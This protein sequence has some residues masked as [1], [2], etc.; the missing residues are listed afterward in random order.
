MHR[1]LNKISEWKLRGKPLWLGEYL[2]LE[3]INYRAARFVIPITVIE[4]KGNVGI[5]TGTVINPNT[6]L[7]CA[8][9]LNDIVVNDYIT[10]N[11]K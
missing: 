3:Y 1:K 4:S 6:I 11:G 2:E 7:T 5:G 9:V 10:I 8:H